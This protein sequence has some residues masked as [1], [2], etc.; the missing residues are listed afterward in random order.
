M[1]SIHDKNLISVSHLC[2][3]NQ[4]SITFFPSYFQGR[5][6]HTG[7]ILV[8]GPHK[9]GVYV[10]PV[11]F[12]LSASPLALIS[13]TVSLP[14]WHSRLSHP[15][16]RI[17]RHLVSSNVFSISSSSITK[18]TCNS[19]RVNKNHKLPFHESF[20]TSSSPLELIF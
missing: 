3:T 11:N 12:K 4:V 2:N 20:L 6:L 16:N 5:D 15:S 17:V 8:Q 10:W 9:D 13:A 18:F 1:C 19:C 7:A 14:L